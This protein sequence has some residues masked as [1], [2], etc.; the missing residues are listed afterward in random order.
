M[1]F[2]FS[3]FWF[4]YSFYKVNLCLIMVQ[5][6]S[7]LW[8]GLLR[9]TRY[10]DLWI[11]KQTFL[12]Q[13]HERFPPNFS[14]LITKISSKILV[15]FFLFLRYIVKFSQLGHIGKISSVNHFIYIQ[16]WVLDKSRELLDVFILHR[17]A[18]IFFGFS[19]M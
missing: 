7:F 11:C 19:F 9:R 2:W 1:R 15:T 5:R 13:Y 12:T 16:R 18:G 14:A 8:Y 10:T 4:S 6:E 3:S 17:N